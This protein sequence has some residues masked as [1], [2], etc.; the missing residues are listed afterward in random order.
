MMVEN[1]PRFGMLAAGALIA[2]LVAPIRSQGCPVPDVPPRAAL[3]RLTPPNANGDVTVT[4]GSG[5]VGLY[6]VNVQVR[7]GTPAGD[8]L[9]VQLVIGGARSNTV[10]IGVE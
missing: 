9:P 10:T 1:M 7:D 2:A 6:Q 5:F 4:G 3:I 8:A